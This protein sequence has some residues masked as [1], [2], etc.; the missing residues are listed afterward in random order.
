MAIIHKALAS[1]TFRIALPQLIISSSLNCCCCPRR[2]CHPPA[3]ESKHLQPSTAVRYC[4]YCHR[5][6]QLPPPPS[7]NHHSSDETSHL[8][9]RNPL[10]HMGTTTTQAPL[11]HPIRR[12]RAPLVRSRCPLSSSHHHSAFT[13]H[14]IASRL[15][16][17]PPPN[18][19]LSSAATVSSCPRRTSHPPPKPLSPLVCSWANHILP[20]LLL[21]LVHRRCP[22]SSHLP[23]SSLI[24][25][26][27]LLSIAVTLSCG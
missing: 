3:I 10:N 13:L 2:C 22:L 18:H 4:H 7:T 9:K 26:C 8:L 11:I 27:L 17:P 16:W 6:P 23:L 15:C 21:P 19:Y 1:S 5:C 25:H 14:H 20:Q 12:R 24:Y